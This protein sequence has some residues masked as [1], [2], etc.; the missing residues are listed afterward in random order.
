MD[1]EQNNIVKKHLIKLEKW[2]LDQE[3]TLTAF[4]GGIDSSLV[5]YLSRY[6]L[7]EKGIGCISLSPSLKTKDYN[8]AVQFCK[9]YDIQLETIKTSE[10]NDDNYLSNPSNRCYFCKNHLYMGLEELR[11]KYPNHTLLNGANLDD[12]GDYRPGLQSAKEFKILSPL[13]ECGIDKQAVRAI[14]KYMGLTHWDKPASPCLSSR[15]PYGSSITFDKL[16]QIEEAE[17]ILN[18]YGFEDVRVRHYGEEARVEV[19]ADELPKLKAV[20]ADASEEI[21]KLG[22]ESCTIDD[23]GLVSGKLNR[24]LNEQ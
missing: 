19:P 24:V 23:E 2:F 11:P 5:L 17:Y 3:Q 14:A 21:K 9:K 16:K 20:F 15:V 4:S 7:G 13:V 12:L 6:F 1:S 10:L 22:F 18:G 8:D